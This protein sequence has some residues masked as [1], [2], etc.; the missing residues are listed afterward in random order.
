MKNSRYDEYKKEDLKA[1]ELQMEEFVSTVKIIG[2]T[3]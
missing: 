1:A 2:K 3:F